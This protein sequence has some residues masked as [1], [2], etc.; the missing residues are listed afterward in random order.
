MQ[1]GG[2]EYLLDPN[3]RIFWG[4]LCSSLVLALV[5]TWLHPS[6][7]RLLFAK[8]IWLHKSAKLDYIYFIVSFFIKIFLIFPIVVSAKSVAFF[9]LNNLIDLFGFVQLN[10]SRGLIIFSYTFVL[11]V[12]SDFSRYLL[13][14]WLHTYKFLWR[15]HKVHHSA[16]VLTPLTFYRVHPVENLLFGLR[17][18][19][20]I[21]VVTGVFL[22][23]FGAKIHILD[24]LGVNI[25]VFIFSFL[26]SNLRHSHIG[27]SYG[28]LEFI[29]ISP[30]QHQMHHSPKY[31][32]KNFGGYLSIWDILFG[33]FCASKN[34]GYLKF[35]LTKSQ[36]SAY[37]SVKALLLEPLR[38]KK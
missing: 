6:Q 32:N 16:R 11:F 26:G 10:L 17:Y 37:G 34:I 4:Y 9:V 29:F 13:H 24:V 7:K 28:I 27:L 31:T 33:S 38:S 35:G 5:Y 1:V 21:G 36:M 23:F 3:R 22:Y 25:F 15:F 8:E 19:L 14:R 20:V 12:V 2:L 18:S 30:K